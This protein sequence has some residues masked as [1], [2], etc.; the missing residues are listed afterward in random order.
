MSD[1]NW[2][3]LGT[4]IMWGQGLEDPDKIHNVLKQMLQERFTDRSVHMTFLA[5]SGAST[6][7][8]PDG[9]VDTHREPRVHGEVPAIYPTILQE[10][11]EF[12][13]LC[14]RPESIDLVLLDAGINVVHI[15]KV[16]P[17]TSSHQI[18]EWVEIYCHQHMV[19]LRVVQTLT[20]DLINGLHI[21][22]PQADSRR[23]FKK[24]YCIL[25]K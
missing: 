14:I 22:Q 12:D 24:I 20:A 21:N 2:V 17:R 16:I 9:S 23:W 25:Y 11:E 19:L 7:F 5:H 10:I 8:K 15:T 1:F 4:S 13:E 3:V 18:E 6:G